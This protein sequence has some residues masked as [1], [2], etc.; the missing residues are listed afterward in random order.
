MDL[1]AALRCP[2]FRL[3]VSEAGPQA[4]SKA[5]RVTLVLGR[6]GELLEQICRVAFSR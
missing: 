6:L 3:D 2:S 4:D 5:G 1:L